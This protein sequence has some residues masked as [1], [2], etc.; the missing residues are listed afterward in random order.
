MNG[1]KRQ[2]GSIRKL[3]SG[4]WQARCL[5]P[6]TNRTVSAPSTFKSRGD[7]S[8]WLAG[9]ESGSM[10]PTVAS[11]ARTDERLG[12]YAAAWITT[13]RLKPRTRELYEGQL[14]LHIA[15]SLGDARVSKLEPRHIRAWHAEISNGH[16]SNVSVAKVYRLLR[17]ILA[18]AVEDGLL[19]RNPCQIKHG[20]VE[21]SAERPIPTIEEV[22][23]L[24]AALPRRYALVP[25]LAAASGLRRGEIFG[26]ARRHISFEQKAIPIER[27]LQEDN[28][29]GVE[30]VEPKSIDGVRTVIM[31][32]RL[33]AMVRAHLSEYVGP[34]ADSLLFTNT[35]GRAI[36]SV[37]WRDAW[38]EARRA[39]DLKTVRLH[40]LRHLAGTLNAQAGATIKESM[41]FLGHG[42]PR[43]AMRYQ[44]AAS[45]RASDIAERMNDL[46]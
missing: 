1:R 34:D 33:M 2:Y 39:T 25:W 22:E 44:H 29:V 32:P 11:R 3:P 27:A 13:R 35:K 21:R 10:D 7:A 16:L 37:V 24:S 36:R 5:D 46:L 9:M 15:P 45:D 14:R 26:L 31:P 6:L 19:S 40:D 17:S 8:R 41:K 4:R 18:T 20:G 42:S 12:G 28:G 43:A 23:K 38:T 30:F